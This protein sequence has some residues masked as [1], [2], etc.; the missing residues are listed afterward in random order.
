MGLETAGHDWAIFTNSSIKH[1][2]LGPQS[3]V[4]CQLGLC[5]IEST[6]SLPL[7][8]KAPLQSV[9]VDLMWMLLMYRQRD[10][11]KW[12]IPKRNYTQV[13]RLCMYYLSLHTRIHTCRHDPMQLMLSTLPL[14]KRKRRL[15]E[16][17]S[18]ALG[19]KYVAE[20]WVW[21]KATS[22]QDEAPQRQV[23]PAETSGL[24]DT[25][26]L[27]FV[28]KAGWLSIREKSL[29]NI[30]AAKRTYYVP[31]ILHYHSWSH[32]HP[33]WEIQDS[34]HSGSER[35]AC[36]GTQVIPPAKVRLLSPTFPAHQLLS[37]ACTGALLSLPAI[38]RWPLAF[39]KSPSSR[40]C[41]SQKSWGN[42]NYWPVGQASP[43]CGRCPGT[44]L[45]VDGVTGFCYQRPPLPCLAMEAEGFRRKG[46][47]LAS[48]LTTYLLRWPLRWAPESTPVKWR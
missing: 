47:R 36:I 34:H 15:R 1:V 27:T 48:H 37:E 29:A 46:A 30:K 28:L 6:V 22:Y 39:L 7:L 13:L 3:S 42:A 21:T 33:I 2:S 11:I 23:Q 20:T 10:E 41:A 16:N 9:K 45:L 19:S 26:S 25:A 32:T 31:G 17:I 44:N 40:T 8:P 18:L 12:I 14:Q 35:Q 4:Y 24:P 43:A 38:A 5:R